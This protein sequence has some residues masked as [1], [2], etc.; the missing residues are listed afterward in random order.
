[1]KIVWLLIDNETIKLL[2][3]IC[4]IGCEINK[5]RWLTRIVNA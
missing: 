2:V 5:Q 1:M 3:Y 4:K